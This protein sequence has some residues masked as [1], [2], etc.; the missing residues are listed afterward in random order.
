QLQHGH[1]KG[2][3]GA[4]PVHGPCADR[5]QC[6]P[7]ALIG[8]DGTGVKEYCRC[9]SDHDGGSGR[10]ASS[11]RSIGS[12]QL[13][14]RKQL[15]KLRKIGFVLQILNYRLRSLLILPARSK[16]ARSRRAAARRSYRSN[17]S[18]SGSTR[19]MASADRPGS[20]D[21]IVAEESL[22]LGTMNLPRSSALRTRIIWESLSCGG[23]NSP[24]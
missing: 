8:S 16:A 23:C 4:I 18:N 9:C 3:S 5:R 14:I 15:E 1:R 11:F 24:T 10:P 6:A 2:W 13:E 12:C 22:G 17:L 21:G 20:C 19:R 7:R